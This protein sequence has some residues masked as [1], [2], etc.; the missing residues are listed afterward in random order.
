MDH[1]THRNQ[2]WFKVILERGCGGYQDYFGEYDCRHKYEWSCDDCPIV[3][4][5]YYQLSM[6]KGGRNDF[7]QLLAQDLDFA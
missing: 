3:T 4:D 7:D 5:K 1:P 6:T 2:K